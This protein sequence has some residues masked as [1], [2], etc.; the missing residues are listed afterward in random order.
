MESEI[1]MSY[2]KIVVKLAD[3]DFNATKMTNIY[4]WI[5]L[6]G[7]SIEEHIKIIYSKSESIQRFLDEA[8]SFIQHHKAEIVQ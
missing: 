2:P 1:I 8:Y 3:I 4:D 7:I 6:D 5:K